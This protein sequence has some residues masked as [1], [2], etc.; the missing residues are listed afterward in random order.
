MLGM[1]E[2]A[3]MLAFAAGVLYLFS[4]IGAQPPVDLA[5]APDLPEQTLNELRALASQGDKIRAIKRYRELTG[6][7]LRDA[8]TF[9]EQ[10]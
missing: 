5:N 1:I 9:V 6:V 10:L 4:R 8:K 2:A 7:G 3:L